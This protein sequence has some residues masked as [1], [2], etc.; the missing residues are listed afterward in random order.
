[1]F[2]PNFLPSGYASFAAAAEPIRTST[3]VN[4]AIFSAVSVLIL[5]LVIFL[6][7]KQWRKALA[8]SRALGSPAGQALGKLFSPVFMIW[9]P[10]IIVGAL[11]AWF[12]ALWQASRTIATLRPYYE[13]GVSINIIWLF[14]LA[15]SMALLSFAGLVISGFIMAKKPVLEQLQ[16]GAQKRR[17]VK[18]RV[19]VADSESIQGFVMGKLNISPEPPKTTPKA[20]RAALFKHIARH[21]LRSPV[22]SA[23]AAVVALFFVIS[24]GWLNYTIVST[25]Y[26]I[27]RLWDTTI[28]VGEIR[29]DMEDERTMDE[30][31]YIYGHA[32]IS[33][34]VLDMFLGTGFV[35]DM[36]LE[37]LW[38]F[39]AVYSEMDSR[40]NYVSDLIFGVSTFEG[41]V[42]ENTRT[43]MD[44]ALG[45]MGEDI[46][47]SFA[48]G[49][50][51]EHFIFGGADA[52]VPIIVRDSLLMQYGYNLGDYLRLS[53][54]DV[55]VQIIGS[56]NHGL[57]RAVNSFGADTSVVIMPLDALQYHTRD[58]WFFGEE[59]WDLGGLSYKT[60]NIEIN[61]MRNREIDALPGLVSSALAFNNLGG[62]VG[63]LPLEFIMNDHELRN[64]IEPMEQNLA[65]L[66]VL[67][68]IAIGVAIILSIGLSMLIMLQ[69]AKNAAI[70]RILGKPKLKA[71]VAL[72]GEQI[73]VCAVGVVFGLV[74]LVAIGVSAFAIAPL[75]LALMYFGGSAIG[76]AIGAYLISGKTPLELLQTRE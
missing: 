69:N 35:S 46:D 7:L 5:A 42:Q 24:L 19:L 70:M 75:L 31:A 3:A 20:A 67:Y 68:P 54:P 40:N 57:D 76:S 28:V 37:A 47:I 27:N 9:S 32:P 71:Q 4:V 73:I 6:Y 62:F 66:R 39:G 21:I 72:C 25:E 51:A 59:G 11:V 15:G 18:K 49:F 36:Y 50:G 26:E 44:D 8:V 13:E 10:A 12:F 23:L 53:Y 60:A 52:P 14:V 2:A 29:R 41:F 64:V 48:D 33:Q 61:P 34:G 1:G 56:F 45:I 74:V 22:K 17:K 30:W 43:A 65:L 38:Q 63:T 55:T 58:S 16:G